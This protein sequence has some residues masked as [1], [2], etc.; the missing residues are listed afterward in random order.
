MFV[1]DCAVSMGNWHEDIRNANEGWVCVAILP[2][3]NK[4]TGHYGT[5]KGQIKRVH[6]QHQVHMQMFINTCIFEHEC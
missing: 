2:A 5:N 1:H 6:R 4:N 3:L